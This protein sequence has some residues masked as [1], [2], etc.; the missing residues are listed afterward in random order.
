MEEPLQN[1]L[2]PLERPLVGLLVQ[3]N[4]LHYRVYLPLAFQ[5]GPEVFSEETVVFIEGFIGLAFFFEDLADGHVVGELADQSLDGFLAEGGD[6]V[7]QGL[8]QVEHV[9]VQLVGVLF[10]AGSHEESVPDALEPF[11]VIGDGAQRFI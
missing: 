8:K 5:D 9:E 2:L 7:H 4:L 3:H 10:V 1:L 6:I 11:N